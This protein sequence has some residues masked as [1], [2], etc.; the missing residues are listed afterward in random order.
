MYVLEFVAIDRLQQGLSS[1]NPV[2]AGFYPAQERQK[3][4]ESNRLLV[5]CT[6]AVKLETGLDW[7]KARRDD[8]SSAEREWE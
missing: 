8:Q 1:T 3:M 5:E 4:A 7:E 6:L 2:L